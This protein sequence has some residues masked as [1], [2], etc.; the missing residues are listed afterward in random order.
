VRASDKSLYETDALSLL[1][2]LDD[3]QFT[4]AY[5]DPPWATAAISEIKLQEYRHF[6]S[7]V[8]QQ[9]RR[10]LNDSGTLYFHAPPISQVDYRL[11]INQV[12]SGQPSSVIVWRQQPVVNM[13]KS[14]P[15]NRHQYSVPFL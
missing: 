6:I 4:L 13:S 7:C 14:A 5:I 3:A 1:E 8:V 12:F 10:L 2:R 15:H 9:C 11:I